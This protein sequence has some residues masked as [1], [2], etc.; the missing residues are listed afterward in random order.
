MTSGFNPLTAGKDKTEARRLL[1]VKA[2]KQP[3]DSTSL[4]Q[5]TPVQIG[6]LGLIAVLIFFLLQPKSDSKIIAQA[7]QMVTSNQMAQWADAR[8]L[9]E[10][11]MTSD[12]P[13][14]GEATELYYESKQKTLLARAETGKNS[15]TDSDSEKLF[16]EAVG[17]QKL[18]QY[19]KASELLLK[20]ANDPDPAGENRHVKQAA[21]QLY[22]S[23]NSK[24]QWPSDPEEII[25]KIA[26]TENAV[27]EVELATAQAA[28]VELTN[29]LQTKNRTLL[30]LILKTRR[31][32]RIK[33]E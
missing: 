23:L 5:R 6:L 2:A 22:D 19:P 14:S 18:G 25:A 7:Q 33:G 32:A 12:R 4:L 29:Q 10:P 13:L 20:L 3:T 24:L 9:L 1:G 28:L 17:L 16:V 30:R 21:Q 26:S 27:T 11:I 8:I 31:A 15:S